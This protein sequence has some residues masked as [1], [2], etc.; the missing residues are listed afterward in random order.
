M[1]K[2]L[3]D[4]ISDEVK[5]NPRLQVRKLTHYSLLPKINILYRKDIKR[6][7]GMMNDTSL[8]GRCS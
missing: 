1:F 7:V 5:A 2:K 4:K 6:C 8:Q 3:K